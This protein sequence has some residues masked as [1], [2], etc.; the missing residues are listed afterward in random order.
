MIFIRKNNQVVRA[1]G[2]DLREVVV[3]VSASSSS[4]VIIDKEVP[5]LTEAQFIQAYNNVVDGK[6]VYVAS[7]NDEIFVIKQVNEESGNP[8]IYFDYY[9]SHILRY[10]LAESEV[11]ITAK[12]YGGVGAV[13]SVNGKAGVVVLN[14]SDLLATNQATIQANLERIDGLIDDANSD[15]EDLQDEV[16]TVR[17][18]AQAKTN[19]YVV[20][21]LADITGTQ[22]EDGNFT[23]VS[24]ITGVDLS[25]LKIGDNIFVVDTEAPDFWVSA[26]TPVV[27]LNKL[28]T[29]KI[30][31]E[32]YYTKD[33]VDA[34]LD[35]K[36][37]VGDSYTKQETDTL[38]G[39]KAN[40]DEVYSKTDADDTFATKTELGD[41][42]DK[43]TARTITTATFN[44]G[45]NSN[46]F[47]EFTQPMTALTI[48]SLEVADG[49]NTPAFAFH[50]KLATGG[51]VSFTPTIKWDCGNPQFEA[52]VDY[53]VV[54]T[55]VGSQYFGALGEHY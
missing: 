46:E 49:D 1:D 32:N 42:Q 7:E 13:V 52:D 17:D 8:V 25:T 33:E 40:A 2:K 37:D 19:S 38:L 11:E 51:V 14:A 27:K 24:A 30:D 4:Q 41:K 54:I 48:A 43:S 5:V 22:D 16:A 50:F 12:E 36:A 18:I 45:L 55:K 3:V 21:L 29:E 44:G 28:Q 47:T 10:E 6:V 34:L 23:S 15:I 53:I 31:I 35:D 26:I 9:N 39:D 20:S